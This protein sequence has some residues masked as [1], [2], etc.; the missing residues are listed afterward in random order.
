MNRF[1]LETLK[2]KEKNITRCLD[3]VL[4]LILRNAFFMWVD[5]VPKC[6]HKPSI[7]DRQPA[8]VTS[9]T[10]LRQFPKP[11]KTCIRNEHMHRGGIR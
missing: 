10:I 2:T 11:F 1:L 6:D 8:S 9:L 7:P 3:S 5:K 4:G